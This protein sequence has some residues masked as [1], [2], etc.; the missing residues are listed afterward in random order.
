M[1]NPHHLAILRRDDQ[2]VAV[3][4]KLEMTDALIFQRYKFSNNYGLG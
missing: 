4:G 3:I 1:E 2:C